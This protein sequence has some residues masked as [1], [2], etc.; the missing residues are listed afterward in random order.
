[1][2]Y[3]WQAVDVKPYL[4]AEIIYYEGNDANRTGGLTDM[5]YV[6]YANEYRRALVFERRSTIN[7]PW[8]RES[9]NFYH[10]ADY[11]NYWAFR[12][13][14]GLKSIWDGKI[15]L[16]GWIHYFAGTDE[17]Y[18][19]VRGNGIGW[20]L[21]IIAVYHYTEDLTFSLGLG[22]FDA[23]DDFAENRANDAGLFPTTGGV[24]ADDD[25]AWVIIFN[26]TLK[27]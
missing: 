17:T 26:T 1:M 10:V 23:S 13:Y 15:S 25:A 19:N 12:L 9:E 2:V 16:E 5:G 6:G 27:W 24:G 22:Y 21:D 14:G 11:N 18:D 20:E 7:N 8:A 4:A 3:T